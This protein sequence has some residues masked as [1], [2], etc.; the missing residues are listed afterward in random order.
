MF[1]KKYLIG[2][3]KFLRGMYEPDIAIDTKFS[4]GIIVK[5]SEKVA[6]TKDLVAICRLIHL[7]VQAKLIKKPAYLNFN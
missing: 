3:E 5:E 7:K 4:E 6:K 1:C 2:N